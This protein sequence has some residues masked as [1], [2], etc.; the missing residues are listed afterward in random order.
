MPPT[1]WFVQWRRPDGRLCRQRLRE[2]ALRMW[3]ESKPQGQES[4]PAP[5]TRVFVRAPPLGYNLGRG[6]DWSAG[7]TQAG[8]HLN[9]SG[10]RCQSAR[11]VSKEPAFFLRHLPTRLPRG[12]RR[13]RDGFL[14]DHRRDPSCTQRAAFWGGATH[15]RNERV[16]ND[17]LCKLQLEVRLLPELP[18]QP[19]RRGNLHPDVVST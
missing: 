10:S 4:R 15:I 13:R 9:V 14:Q 5:R 2:L 8:D 19:T 6:V 11:V 12:P 1:G 16:G 18:D 17:L 3:G 7:R